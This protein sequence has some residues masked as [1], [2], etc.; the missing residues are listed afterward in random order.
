MCGIA[1]ALRLD[2]SARIDSTLVERMAGAQ[3]H[4]GPDEDGVYLDPHARA[5]FAFRRLSIIDVAH[6]HQPLSN[7]DETVW[8]E[9]NG[10]IYN[11]TE[12]RGELIDRGHT[13]RTTGDS[14]VIVH[15]WEEWGAACFERLAGMFAIAIWDQRSGELILARDRFG[16]KPLCYAIAANR[17]LFASELKAIV[18]TG[19]PRVID[20]A[21][22]ANY[23]LYQYVPAPQCIYAGWGKLPPGHF[24]RI[25]ADGTPQTTPVR[26]WD[27]PEAPPDGGRAMS[28][29]DALD[30]LDA[31]LTRAVE[32]RLISDVPLG[33]FLSGGVDSSI[34]VGLMRRLGVQPL[35]TFSIGFPDRRY[36][37]RHHARAVAERFE[38]EHHESVVTPDAMTVVDDLAWAYDE[39]FA[40][41]SAIP[42]L[43]LSRWTRQSVTVAL[44]GDGGDE[45]FGG[46]DRYRA[47]NLAARLDWAPSALRG[48]VA[49]AGHA[50][51]SGSAKSHSRRLHRLLTAIGEAPAARY[52]AWIHVFTPALLSSGLRPEWRKAMRIADAT[53]AFDTIYN[54][55]AGTPADRAMRLDMETYLPGDLLQKVDI[56]SMAA[57]ISISPT[58]VISIG[59]RSSAPVR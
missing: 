37:E 2:P 42:T 40:D 21:A 11:F 12:L 39:P 19:A 44:T 24:W 1:G 38:T 50:I 30:Q 20:P 54:A 45:L 7:E 47:A 29:E 53:G 31:L 48:M 10:E 35:R 51:P 15:A 8:L 4:R 52:R 9:F 28:E 25:R 27:I 46:Y 36:D 22:L 26:Y 23:L 58:I 14:E 18:A 49:G 34:V 32:K 43:L 6:S 55:A 57:S 13:F 41:S 59:A 5:G 16:K 56:A 3:T 33:A 17:L